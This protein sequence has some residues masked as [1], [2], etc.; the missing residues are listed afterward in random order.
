MFLVATWNLF[1]I[2]TRY[3]MPLLGGPSRVDLACLR[4]YLLHACRYWYCGCHLQDTGVGRNRTH[5]SFS[6]IRAVVYGFSSNMRRKL[7]GL[8][9]VILVF[10]CVL[11]ATR[12]LPGV[13]HA[14]SLW[15]VHAR[16]T[17]Y[18]TKQIC[19]VVSCIILLL[20]TGVRA[21]QK[22][23]YSYPWYTII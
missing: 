22:C 21:D 11:Y 5:H 12:I 10:F 9:R 4:N 20:V 3:R 6:S 8:R 2:V 14:Y 19:G 7:V 15:Y 23:S 16:R 1:V 13:F 17:L 18:K